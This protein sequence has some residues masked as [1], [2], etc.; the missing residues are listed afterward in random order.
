MT[1][2]KLAIFI[3]IAVFPFS[4]FAKPLSYN[5]VDFVYVAD[6]ELEAGGGSV[7]GDGFALTGS[8]LVSDQVFLVGG[9]TT[10]EYDGAG[11]DLELNELA[12]G[13]GLKHALQDDLH[14]FATL[15]YENFEIEI[16]GIIKDDEDGFGARG[17]LRWALNPAFELNGNVRY[18]DISDVEGTFFQVGGTYALNEQWDVLADYTTGD[19]D[20]DGG[21][22]IDRDDLRIA[23]RFNF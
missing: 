5:Y 4:A 21:P 22:T 15:T 16:P 14:V 10:V 13:F 11:A 3:V 18:L 6:T 1:V 17:G 8:A 2:R 7:D 23:A 20:V 19:Y 9:Y 12:F